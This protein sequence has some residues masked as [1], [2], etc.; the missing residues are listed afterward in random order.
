MVH[1]RVRLLAV[2][3]SFGT[4]SALTSPFCT[5]AS[6]VTRATSAER[7]ENQR[8]VKFFFSDTAWGG[9]PFSQEEMQGVMVKAML[10]G[11]SACIEEE[12]THLLSAPEVRVRRFAAVFEVDGRVRPPKLHSGY[13]LELLVP[14]SRKPLS[15]ELENAETGIVNRVEVEPDGSL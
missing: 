8:V 11:E 14:H 2:L 5:A 1:K 13:E 4:M 6:P 3:V 9:T 7:V 15:V 10:S 12:V